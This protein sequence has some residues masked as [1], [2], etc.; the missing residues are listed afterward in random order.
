MIETG[1]HQ[2]LMHGCAPSRSGMTYTRTRCGLIV[3]DSCLNPLYA[4]MEALYIFNP[5]PEST[6]VS[7]KQQL[8]ELTEGCDLRSPF[9]ADFASGRRRYLCRTF[10]LDVLPELFHTNELQ[11][12]LAFLFERSR[13]CGADFDLVATAYR[14]TP[15]ELDSLTLL[16]KGLTSKEIGA[17]MRV[18]PNTVKAFLRSL[19]GKMGVSTRTELMRKF[20]DHAYMAFTPGAMP[21][22]PLGNVSF[23]R[24][25]EDRL[26]GDGGLG[27]A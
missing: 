23:V 9:I 11:P 13:I 18:S 26:N 8:A 24:E 3:T 27:N 4:N 2:A 15:R 22:Q 19:M 10:P 21:R 20:L 17:R 16:T 12:A 5:R 7:L 1:S 25:N 6:P 14:L